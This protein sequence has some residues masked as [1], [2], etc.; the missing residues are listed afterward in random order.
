MKRYLLFLGIL[1]LAL[2]I[3]REALRHRAPKVYTT[4]SGRIEMC[5]ACHEEKPE[6]AHA[7]EVVGCSPCHLGDPLRIDRQLAHRGIIKNPA[8][9]RVVEK[10]CGQPACHPGYPER[11]KK[12]LMA[13]NRGIIDTL[14]RYWGEVPAHAPAKRPGETVRE[15][16]LSG[17]TSLALD[18]FRKLCGTCHLWLEKGKYPGFL[19][20]K[21]GGCVAC[22]LVPGEKAK[23]HPVLTRR[24]PVENCTRCHNRSGRIGLTY[25]GLYEDEGYG[26]PL[27]EGE[28]G[29]ETLEDGRFVDLIPPDLH[30]KAG[31]TCADCHLPEETMGDGKEYVHFEES[32]EVTCETCHGGQGLTRKGRRHP[33]VV[34]KEGR[35]V[36]KD[37]AGKE[38]PLKAP[39]PVKCRHEVHRRLSCQACHAPR[40]P[41]CFGCH[42]RRDPR[43]TQLDKLAG[44]ETAGAWEEF[45]SY[46]R[47]ETPTLGVK[48]DEVLIIVP[49]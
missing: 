14:R 2:V 19:G 39:D 9:L 8:D 49:G 25:Q 28:F 26:A 38:H 23:K 44:R 40:V 34:E 29:A 13:T 33:K 47:Y 4:T 1:V 46:M 22:H 48:G 12:S 30:Y 21:G 35:L 18:Y 10:T 6:K 24:I 16:M 42:V 3:G 20:E 27:V 15:L 37:N 17:E 11:V 32:V 43:E 7:R 45:R 41:Q 36:L 31:L 5:L